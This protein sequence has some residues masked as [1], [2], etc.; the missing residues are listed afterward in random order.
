MFILK[1]LLN[2]ENISMYGG[3]L[4]EFIWPSWRRNVKAIYSKQCLLCEVSE[5]SGFS[6]ARCKNP[7]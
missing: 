1:H 5:I 2:V 7:I 4:I 6:G 3:N